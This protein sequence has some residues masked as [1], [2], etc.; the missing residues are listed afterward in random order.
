M[1]SPARAPHPWIFAIC[2]CQLQL[3]WTIAIKTVPGLTCTKGRT[4][5]T[6]PPLIAVPRRVSFASLFVGA[7]AC[8]RQEH[9]V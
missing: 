8:L 3:I 7:F 1:S 5:V 2:L 9:T 6:P 4:S